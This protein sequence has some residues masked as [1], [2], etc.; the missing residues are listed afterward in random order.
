MSK[1]VPPR[2]RNADATRAAIL[3][4]A[5]RAFARAGYDGVGVREIAAGAGISAMMVNRYFGSKEQLFAEVVAGIMATPIIL[6]PENLA[7]RSLGAALAEGVVAQTAPG[8]TPLDGFSIMMHSASSERAATIARDEIERHYHEQLSRAL[9]GGF[10]PERAAII[11]AIV[12]GVQAMRQVM[13][14]SALS[15][16]NPASLIALLTPVFDQLVA[17]PRPARRRRRTPKTD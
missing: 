12:T 15:Q 2:P 5:R 13:R 4:S 9:G 6:T 17:R 3:S 14:L 10:A 1:K 7:S 11:L 8:A 16:A